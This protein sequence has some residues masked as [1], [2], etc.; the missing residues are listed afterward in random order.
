MQQEWIYT[1][2]SA[3]ILLISREKIS[4]PD[5]RE[6][7]FVSQWLGHTHGYGRLS[8]VRLASQENSTPRNSSLSY[9]LQ[10]TPTAHCSCV[11]RHL[12]TSF[13]F[14]EQFHAEL[15]E[16]SRPTIRIFCKTKLKTYVSFSHKVARQREWNAGHAAEYC[17]TFSS[18]AS[19]NLHMWT[20][21]TIAAWS[22]RIPSLSRP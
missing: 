22:I 3:S 1:W 4:Q 11:G 9:Q 5:Y 13:T 20:K 2:V 17:R 10:N 19:D 8:C 18:C 12:Q 16:N 6:R 14:P 7:F 15:H 21:C